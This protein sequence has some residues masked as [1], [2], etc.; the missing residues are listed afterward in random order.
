MC[1]HG[2][3]VSLKFC[4]SRAY[5]GNVASL[6]VR[7]LRSHLADQILAM[8][9]GIAGGTHLYALRPPRTTLNASYHFAELAPPLSRKGEWPSTQHQPCLKARSMSLQASLKA[10]TAPKM[11]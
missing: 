10:L 1:S 8:D 2:Y 11:W 5:V 9:K 4:C 6:S 3:K 7:L